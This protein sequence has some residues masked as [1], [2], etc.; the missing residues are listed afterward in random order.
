MVQME[1]QMQNDCI[2][3]VSE[4]YDPNPRSRTEGSRCYE[5]G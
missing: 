4:F 5:R 2:G 1:E 3:T